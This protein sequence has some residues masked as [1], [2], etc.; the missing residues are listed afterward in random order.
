MGQTE[1][2]TA[3]A[4]RDVARLRRR[5][6][7]LEDLLHST[8]RDDVTTRAVD[9]RYRLAAQIARLNMWDWDIQSNEI[10]RNERFHETFGPPAPN[11]DPYEY[12]QQRIHPDDRAAVEERVRAT[13]Q[14]RADH[15]ENSYRLRLPDGAYAQVLDRAV[16]ERDAA[17][18]AIRAIG[19]MI[20]I[21]AQ[22]QAADAVAD[23][24]RRYRELYE[25]FE[26]GIGSTDLAGNFQDCNPAY[27]KMLGYTID[28][29]HTKTYP[30]LTPAAWHEAERRIVEDKVIPD[31][32]SGLYE[33]EYIRKDGTVF[34]VELSTYLARDAQGRPVGLWA[35]VRDISERK[36]VEA[37]L[38]ENERFLRDVFDAIQD[39][40]SVLDRDLNI[41]RTNRWM[42]ARYGDEQ[43]LA[44]HRCYEVYQH[45]DDVCPGC[46]TVVAMQTGQPTSAEVPYPDAAQPSMWFDVSA[47]PLKDDD[48]AATGV[49]EYI[50]DITSRK[51]AEE[52]LRK[53]EAMLSEMSRIVH[54]GAWEVALDTMRVS[55]TD[56]V[57]RILE[58]PVGTAPGFDDVIAY[59]HEEDRAPLRHALA[60]ASDFGTPFDREYRV[61]TARDRQ[62]WVR[63]VGQREYDEQGQP[64]RLAGTVQDITQ[65]KVAEEERREL[66]AQI[67]HAQKLE[68]LGVLAGGIAH[69]FNNLLVGILGYSD[70][71]REELPTGSPVASYIDGVQHSARRAADLAH[72]MLAYSGK[73][74][75]IIESIN[76]NMLVTEMMHLLEVSVSKKAVLKF[77]FAHNLPA[78]EVD[79]T[80]IR[81]VIMNLITNASE[82][83]G[84]ASGVISVSTGAMD[85][86]RSYLRE[87]YLDEDLTEGLY[88]YLEVADTGC[89]M[90]AATQAK[91]FDPFF[92][93]KFTGRGL[94]LAAVL[95]IMRGHRGA[96]KVYSEPGRGT[97]FKALFPALDQ[98]ATAA[99]EVP[100]T[101][102]PAGTGTILLADDEETVRAVGR[103]MLERAGYTVLTA[104]DGRETL[105]VFHE[106]ANDIACVILDLTMPHLGGEEVFRELRRRHKDV[107]VILS[108]GYNEQDVTQR[109]AGKGLAGFIQKPYRRQELLAVLHKVLG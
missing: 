80:Q 81:Q 33:K 72:Q 89:G 63:V 57:F 38:R 70:L 43:S 73:G 77:N 46:P 19:V 98:P 27:E 56:E 61:T 82:A 74:K 87:T 104:V 39:G 9:Q 44:G 106:H 25:R 103:R 3:A 31:G 65:R 62:R 60:Q 99:E 108:S 14:S 4:E 97:T 66:E 40:I 23:S 35:F 2:R 107:R 48:G 22:Q 42:Q 36:R 20:D 34:P 49:I 1:R 17:G 67:Q 11:E 101:R 95:G 109:F 88:V 30:E 71:A 51:R 16:V 64:V 75:F 7:E 18:K 52:A 96:M 55:W 76:L 12:W 86:D 59:F 32:A 47:F 45:R 53:N 29:L 58:L 83:I 68:S 5:I 90:D 79:A 105:E 54:V 50:K 93:T 94:G 28:E 100:A 13:L 102:L 78:I 92:T 91:I 37:S 69:D 41:I 15:W 84:S 10:W 26:D 8:R 21:T 6:A 24:E 85:C